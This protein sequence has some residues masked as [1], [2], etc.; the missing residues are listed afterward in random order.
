M[1][2][3]SVTKLICSLLFPFTMTFGGSSS[4]QSIDDIVLNVYKLETCGCCNGWITHMDERGY[5]SN[6]FHPAD[7][8]GLK[9]EFGIKPQWQSCHTSVTKDGYMFEGHIPEKFIA[10]FLAAPPEGALGLAVP[11]MPIGVP[12]MVMGNRFTPFD[13]LLMKKDGAVEVFSSVKKM[14]DQH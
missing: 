12:G 8:N 6:I 1:K 5:T 13:V 2:K 4:A 3:A 14:E 7:L 9:A 10:Q 11:G